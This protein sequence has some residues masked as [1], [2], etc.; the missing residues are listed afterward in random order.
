MSSALVLALLVGL[1]QALVYSVACDPIVRAMGVGPTSEM[2][3]HAVSYLRVRSLGTPG[4]TVW[5]V[6]QGI[7]RGLGDTAT[8]LKWALA[9]TALNGA[10]TPLTAPHAYRTYFFRTPWTRS[11][12][13]DL[14]D[15]AGAQ[16]LASINA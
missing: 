2:F 16:R 4:A 11:S 9:F 13:S 6:V 10:D 12:S 14:E 8:P 15:M 3:P 7:Y 1:L 5:L